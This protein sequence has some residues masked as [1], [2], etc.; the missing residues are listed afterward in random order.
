MAAV[1][2]ITHFDSERRLAQTS[3]RTGAQ[4]D[5]ACD[6]P[7]LAQIAARFGVNILPGPVMA[8]DEDALTDWLRVPFVLD[9]PTL[10]R[11]VSRLPQA[12]RTYSSGD[13]TRQ[14]QQPVV[15]V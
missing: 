1:T 15:C 6:T 11:A 3:D 9:G 13:L 10:R 4:Q 14:V 8:S 12:W 5:A 2:A 7:V